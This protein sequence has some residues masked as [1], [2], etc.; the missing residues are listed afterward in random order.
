QPARSAGRDIV[1]VIVSTGQD[2]MEM[3]EALCA[4]GRAPQVVVDSTSISIEDSERVRQRLAAAGAQLLAA[5][6]SGNAKVIQAG[7][8]TF[9]CSGP[10]PAFD[11][12]EPYLGLMGSGASYVGEGELSRIAKICHNVYLGIVIQALAEIT[13]LAQKAGMSRHA[14]LDFLNRSVMGSTFSRYKTPALVNLDFRVTFT[15]RLLRKDLD[16][17]LDAARALEVPMPLATLTRELVQAM[18][19]HGMTEK[20]FSELL[21]LQARASGVEL[22]PE[23]VEVGDGLS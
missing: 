12:A 21:V 23:N 17:G 8:L 22:Q 9:V 7:K 6:V 1:F 4:G 20:D 10:R 5:P 3:V 15:P 18:I 16:L 2:V 11:A 19:G 13:L 14:F